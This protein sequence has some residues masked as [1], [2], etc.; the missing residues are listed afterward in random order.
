MAKKNFLIV[1]A[2]VFMLL[3]L[4]DTA[5][6]FTP[7][8][9]INLRDRLS[10]YGAKDVNTSR[11]CFDGDCRS[12]WTAVANPF[13]Q[14]LNTD[15]NV[16][17][18]SIVVATKIA[19]EYL[20]NIF[21]QDLNTTDDVKFGHVNGSSLETSG[22]ADIAGNINLATWAGNKIGVQYISN[23]FDQDLNT[24]NRA[25]FNGI[26]LNNSLNISLSGAG[27]QRAVNYKN[28]NPLA[29]SSY[30][31]ENDQGASIVMAIAG[32]DTGMF[33]NDSGLVCS[34]GSCYIATLNNE[35]IF[36]GASPDGDFANVNFSV[37]VDNTLYALVF[38]GNKYIRPAQ[39]NGGSALMF[40][41]FES[42]VEGGFPY[43]FV[44]QDAA[45][46]TVIT[47]WHNNGKNNSYSGK[48]NSL[49]VIPKLWVTFT[50]NVTDDPAGSAFLFNRSNYLNYVKW[51]PT[52][53]YGPIDGPIQ[54]S[55]D[56]MGEGALL[57][58][59]VFESLYGS[60][61]HGNN[62]VYG[63][64]DYFPTANQNYNV[65]EGGVY[66]TTERSE[67]F[68]DS[69]TNVNKVDEDFD[70]G[71][72]GVF[73]RQPPVVGTNANNWIFATDTIG[74][75]P[76]YN[77]IGSARANGGN[78]FANR[79]MTTGFET[80]NATSCTVSFA[81]A[82]DNMQNSAS[83]RLWVVLENE[84]DKEIIRTNSSY[85]SDVAPPIDLGPID[86]PAAWLDQDD[87]NITFVHSASTSGHQSYIDDVVVNCELSQGIFINV[88]RNDGCYY[89]G[90]SD[91]SVSICYNDTSNVSTSGSGTWQFT[92]N[93]VSFQ[94]VTETDLNV[95]NS[96]TL[97]GT[98]AYDWKD[99]SQAGNGMSKNYQTFSV[100]GNTCL[101]QDSDG[102]SVT[103]DCIGN[104]QL[105]YNTGQDLTSSSA[106]DF[107]TVNT[108]QGDYELYAMNQ[109]V[110]STD[111][112][113]FAGATFTADVN[114]T[115]DDILDVNEIRHTDGSVT[116]DN[117]TCWYAISPGGGT[118]FEVCD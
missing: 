114:M 62:R 79:S 18:N 115:D 85:V 100:A 34:G 72:L 90:P 108:G 93:T 37:A 49:G 39:V 9:N 44:A 61:M 66:V 73:I 78:T 76:A 97:N 109:D 60:A 110:E 116:G 11:I 35:K 36:F 4:A 32:S 51:L 92:P 22:D 33:A 10:L 54:Y 69:V 103:N 41:S 19:K 102:L 99:V 14:T 101:D 42:L 46:D 30:G 113:S 24:S 20:S 80:I 23:I 58:T 2:L 7:V 28:S 84:T 56:T 77:G 88:T 75:Q 68:D 31:I 104:A 17:F 5:L 29:F 106:V 81:Y 117:A 52:T 6:G 15:D 74:G 105:E 86:F 94:D 87:I 38:G 89:A 64:F 63:T 43:I 59:M 112:P 55:A 53:D 95:T 16:Q 8:D 57:H 13:D 67:A 21:D 82:T 65:I 70:T 98:I 45:N 12:N 3:F 71:D 83:N 96:I 48:M 50:G 1:V 107:A 40:Q 118:T 25:S 91:L 26:N 111:K 27:V 47:E